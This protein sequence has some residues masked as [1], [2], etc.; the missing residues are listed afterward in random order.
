MGAT[1]SNDEEL[2]SDI[3]V[4]PLVDVVLVLLIILMVTATAAVSKTIEMD[5][6]RTQGPT[7]ETPQ[8]IAVSLD[9]GGQL[10]FDAEPVNEAEL[11]RRLQGRTDDNPQ[12]VVSAAG[13]QSHARV[14]RLLDLLR[15]EGFRRFAFNVRPSDLEELSL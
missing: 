8:I 12:V 3:N 10:Y 4:T 7:D 6:P 5:L 9:A 11:R 13:A 14:I 2:I 1:S 15:S